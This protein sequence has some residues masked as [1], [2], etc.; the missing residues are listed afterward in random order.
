MANPKWKPH[1]PW[2]SAPYILVPAF[3]LFHKPQ[4]SWG[5]QAEENFPGEQSS[6]QGREELLP[7]CRYEPCNS[8]R[9]ISLAFRVFKG[10]LCQSLGCITSDVLRQQ[11]NAGPGAV[12]HGNCIKNVALLLFREKSSQLS[13]SPISKIAKLACFSSTGIFLLFKR[14]VKALH[15]SG[16]AFRSR[17]EILLPNTSV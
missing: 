7:I 15:I 8:S 12:S 10:H 4:Q 2:H 17:G 5:E 14:E 16:C 11:R 6:L 3:F 9:Q 1:C 13:L